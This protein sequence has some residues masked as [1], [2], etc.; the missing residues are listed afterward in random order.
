MDVH[1]A[2]HAWPR[3]GSTYRPSSQWGV[4]VPQ[5]TGYQATSDAQSE[6]V[7]ACDCRMKCALGCMG[8][9]QQD[10]WGMHALH[11]V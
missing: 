3:M 2:N 6:A 9:I 7:Y 4:R 11:S 5:V 8:Q 1:G 10:P